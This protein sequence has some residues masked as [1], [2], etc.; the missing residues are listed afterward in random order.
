MWCRWACACPSESLRLYWPPAQAL[1]RRHLQHAI[2][3]RSRPETENGFSYRQTFSVGDLTSIQLTESGG[4]VSNGK[5]P[6][7]NQGANSC[8]HVGEFGT[9]YSPFACRLALAP[10]QAL[11]L[12]CKHDTRGR[13]RNHHFKRIAFDLSCERITDHQTFRALCGALHL[14]RLTQPPLEITALVFVSNQRQCFS[15]R[16]RRC[17]NRSH[18]AKQVRTRGVK[19]V[20]ALQLSC[21]HIDLLQALGRTP[22]HRERDTTIQRYD[23][24]RLQPLEKVVELQDLMPVRFFGARSMA[25]ERR[26]GGLHREGSGRSPDRLS[27][28]R[29]GLVDLAPVPPSAIL[30]LERYDLPAVVN[31]RVPPRIVQQHE[32]QQRRRFRRSG[33]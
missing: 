17:L 27:H 9:R 8:A 32:R 5:K 15:I 20:V 3:A 23:R 14:D 12:T 28:K 33:R 7:P 21:E 18:A 19:E 1:D 30:L 22:R 4:A 2:C 10:V 29:E 26:D 24:R 11:H 13:S 6:S 25:M 16:F 31:P